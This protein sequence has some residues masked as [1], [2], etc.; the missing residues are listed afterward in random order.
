[1]TE[2]CKG[3]HILILGGTGSFGQSFLEYI[4][5]HSIDFQ[6]I[7]LFSR[8]ELKHYNLQQKYPP[9]EYPKIKYIIGD[10]RD[11]E[12]L[13]EAMDGVDVL[14][15]AAA[16]KHVYLC[17]Q[18]PTECWKTNVLGSHN[19]VDLLPFKKS[20]HQV[21]F[22]S[23]DK[24]VNPL[25]VYGKSKK[26]AESIYLEANAVNEDCNISVIRYGNVYG[27]SGSL[28]PT[29]E[30]QKEKGVIYIT[31]KRMKRF[32]ISPE[33]AIQSVLYLLQNQKGGE[34]LIP[35]CEEKSIVELAFE[36]APDA[37]IEYI[38]IRDGEKLQEDLM[39][40]E[41]KNVAQKIEEYYIIPS[42]N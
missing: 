25:N 18:N 35:Q 2:N 33:K 1:M 11:K 7:T 21:V 29:I 3:K 22:V 5:H 12:R 15:N 32:F 34:I 4:L 41:E 27:A 38:G 37:K 28:V 36:I 14:I 26:E 39:T 31:D 10:I 16:M 30:K 24:A 23:S 17:E 13:S 9:K 20:I 40:E 19:V 8:D 42:K 6:K